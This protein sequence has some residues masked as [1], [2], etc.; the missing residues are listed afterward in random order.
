MTTV[1]K[2]KQAAINCDKTY[3]STPRNPTNRN[4]VEALVDAGVPVNNKSSRQELVSLLLKHY[5]TETLDD[6]EPSSSDESSSSDEEVEISRP[7]SQRLCLQ[8][9]NITIRDSLQNKLRVFGLSTTG[10]DD[11]MRQRL[12]YR[13][14]PLPLEL[15]EELV[16]RLNTS[17]SCRN[18]LWE[19]Y[20]AAIDC[21][22][23]PEVVFDLEVVTKVF[24][25]Y[26][27]EVV[28]ICSTSSSV[29]A[30][31]EKEQRKRLWQDWIQSR[32]VVAVSRTL[33]PLC[34]DVM[35]YNDRLA[36]WDAGHILARC[37]G[38]DVSDDNLRPICHSCNIEMGVENMYNFARRRYPKAVQELELLVVR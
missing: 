28:Q 12:S 4:L 13:L 2:V 29:V 32:S 31:R 38:G 37:Q 11:E 35:I 10:S 7:S 18:G 30:R 33:C 17:P 9:Q 21:L 8:R 23:A 26:D 22:L 1:A 19:G 24:Q 25:E 36:G 27:E 16:E 20:E 5:C 15:L 14:A 34:K 6:E 3:L